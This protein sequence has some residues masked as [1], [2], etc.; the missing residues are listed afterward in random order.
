L[1]SYGGSI[2][3]PGAPGP[4]GDAGQPGPVGPHGERGFAG[5]KGERGQ[6]GQNGPKG[7]RVS[8]V[9]NWLGTLRSWQYTLPIRR[10]ISNVCR[11]VFYTH[12]SALGPRGGLWPV[13]LVGNP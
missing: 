12:Q 9:N 11:Q 10:G 8:I 7:D 2:G 13:L 1:G 4:K 3:R 5:Q 6:S